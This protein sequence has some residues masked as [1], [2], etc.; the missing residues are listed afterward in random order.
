LL[1]LG[2]SPE[3]MHP[4]WGVNFAC[5]PYKYKHLNTGAILS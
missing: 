1:L 4:G 5:A 2:P 3:Q